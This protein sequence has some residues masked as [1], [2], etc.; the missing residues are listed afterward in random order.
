MSFYNN[1]NDVNAFAQAQFGGAN[2]QASVSV[3]PGFNAAPFQPNFQTL[4][5]QPCQQSFQVTPFIDG[6]CGRNS[7]MCSQR[8][9]G[10]RLEEC[11]SGSIHSPFSCNRFF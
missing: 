7:F 9:T 6:S 1:N 3:Q 8:Y 2:V 10:R 5:Y 4:P 11:C